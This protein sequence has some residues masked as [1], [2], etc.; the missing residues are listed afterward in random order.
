M[1]K[2]GKIYRKLNTVILREIEGE[3]I[4]IPISSRNEDRNLVLYGLNEVGRFIWDQ[5]NGKRTEKEIIGALVKTYDVNEE[6][7]HNDVRTFLSL[8]KHKNIIS[9]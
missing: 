5:I 3:S 7:G 9:F 2:A 8:L 1:K 4:L 6:K